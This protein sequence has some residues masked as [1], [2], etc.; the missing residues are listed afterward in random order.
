MIFRQL[1]DPDSSTLTYL[2]GNGQG[3]GVIIDPVLEHVE[4]YMTMVDALKTKLRWVLDTHV[5]ADHITGSQR[6]R[7][8]TGATTVIAES[9]GAPGYDKLLVDGDTIDFGS[10]SLRVIATPGHTPGSLCYLWRDRLFTGDTLMINACGRTDFQQGS[11]TDMYHS[12]TGK[13]FV[14]PD[15]TLVYPGHDYKGRRVSCIGEEKVLN[16][17]IA[18]KTLEEFVSIM[19]NLNLATPKRIHEAVPANLLGGKIPD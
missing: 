4:T 6:L 12:I 11:A 8:L 13:L 7:Q 17:R 14:L 15:E 2:L 19:D 5:H 3:S 1:F 16:T 10:E 9:C 18:G